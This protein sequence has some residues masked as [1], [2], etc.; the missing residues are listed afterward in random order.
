MGLNTHLCSHEELPA[1]AKDN[2]FIVTGYRRP[3]LAEDDGDA[4]HQDDE[5]IAVPLHEQRTGEKETR[6]RRR[7]VKAGE[8]KN[9]VNGTAGAEL[10]RHDTIAK[11][12]ASIWLY[13]HNER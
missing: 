13:A 12:W 4:G 5:V 6:T 10:F 9:K 3:G 2:A 1:W 8:K 11:C 7:V